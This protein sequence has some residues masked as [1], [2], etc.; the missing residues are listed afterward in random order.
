MKSECLSYIFSP[1]HCKEHLPLVPCSVFTATWVFEWTI[2]TLRRLLDNC[3]GLLGLGARFCKV[4][5]WGFP[6]KK[7]KEKKSNG[8]VAFG[9][10]FKTGFYFFIVFIFC[11][12]LSFLSWF[13]FNRFVIDGPVSLSRMDIHYVRF[14]PFFY[15]TCCD[16]NIRLDIVT[17]AFYITFYFGFSFCLY[18]KAVASA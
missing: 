10:K 6:P 9:G 8:S 5:L 11:A 16:R 1:L 12:C 14:P 18:F 13:A 3:G 2:D 4:I 15:V 7:K 17:I